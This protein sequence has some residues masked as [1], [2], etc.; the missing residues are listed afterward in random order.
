MNYQ[1]N[2]LLKLAIE[3]HGGL[4]R[5]KNVEQVSSRI[6]CGGV[7]WDIKKQPGVV[8]DIYVTVGTKRQYTSHYPFVNQDWHTSFQPDRV[9]IENAKGEV[10]EELLDPRSSFKDHTVETPWSRLQLAYFAG[11]AMWTYFNAPFNFADPEYRVEELEP[12]TEDGEIFRRL[13]VIYPENKATHGPV[14]IFYIDQSGL[15]R[16]H[17][18][19]VVVMGGGGAAHYLFDYIEIEGIKIATKRKAYTRSA[20]NTSLKPHPLLVSIDVS[21]IWLNKTDEQ[22]IIG[23]DA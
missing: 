19:D 4:D 18:Y 21:E 3:A 22:A 1:M 11:Y 13:Q 10:V 20:D 7:L 6:I 2:D 15:I 23:S 5:W 17:D 14:Q 12:W 8:N 9:A 16:R